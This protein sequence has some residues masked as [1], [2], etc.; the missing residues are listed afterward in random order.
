VVNQ[1]D[2]TI[3]QFNI[4]NDGKLYPQ[5]TINTTGSFPLA[6]AVTSSFLFEADTFQPLKTCTKTQPC[7]GS[8]GVFSIGTGGVLATTPVANGSLAYWP[9]A[10]SG[11]ST[12]IVQPTGITVLTSGSN[13]YVYVAAYDTTAGA[14]YI[15][16]FQ[17]QS[18]VLSAVSGSPLYL[19]SSVQP[20]S[21]VSATDTTGSQYVYITDYIGFTVHGFS[22]ASGVLT[23]LGTYPSGSQPSAM[24]VD[25]KYSY[26]YVANAQDGTVWAYSMSSGALTRIG[27]YTAGLQP[28]AIGI[29]PSVGHFLFTANF[30]G[31]NISDFELSPT[32]GTLVNAMNSPYA[33]NALPTALAAVPHKM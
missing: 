29:D 14:G 13:T 17:S 12:D 33:T 11:A 5:N 32:T 20:S 31:N 21:I 9:L 16:A 15:F 7:S 3:V 4:G 1:D 2:G 30:L 18:G 26:A 28:V 24:A 27:I 23:P 6:V 22:V 8:I 25:P 19:G 10:L